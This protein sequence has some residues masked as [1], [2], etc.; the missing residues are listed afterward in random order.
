MGA[1][2]STE[3]GKDR[4][5]ETQQ[6]ERNNEGASLFSKAVVAAGAAAILIGGAAA[7]L[8]S[9]SKSL[10]ERNEL[11]NCST[12]IP[13][14]ISWEPP[15]T[16]CMK[17]NT[18][19]AKRG[20][21]GPAAAGGLIRDSRGRWIRGFKCYMG[22]G[23]TS[24]K[25]ELLG[26]IEGL[27]LARKIGCEKLI[28]ETDN[29]GVV[30]MIKIKTNRQNDNYILASEIQQLLQKGWEVQ[31]CKNKQNRCADRLA[32]YGLE[33]PHVYQELSCPP[34]YRDLHDI[35]KQ[36]SVDVAFPGLY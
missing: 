28:V 25:A 4:E 6:G 19:G 32:N 34:M 9:D 26:L 17:L 20:E 10:T 12:P 2:E 35:L 31:H 36:E 5:A 33:E 24:V 30:Q 8:S 18:D 22:L 16:G 14:S 23:S 11:G 15:T 3:S 1:S 13:K 7:L 27:K 21:D 29:E